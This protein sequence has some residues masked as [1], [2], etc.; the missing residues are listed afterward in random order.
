MTE[1]SRSKLASLLTCS[2]S[3]LAT[4][5]PP[6]FTGSAPLDEIRRAYFNAAV[7]DLEIERCRND[8]P[9]L[10]DL[11]A[12]AFAERQIADVFG[13]LLNLQSAA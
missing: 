4:F 6:N 5:D 3:S 8:D 7:I 13:H 2:A 12:A 11:R 1:Y 9:R 10:P